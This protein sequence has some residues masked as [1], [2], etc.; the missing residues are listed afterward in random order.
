[1][2]VLKTVEMVETKIYYGREVGASKLQEPWRK[3]NVDKKSP[4][5]ERLCI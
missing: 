3:G 2:R 4:D 1:V 5:S